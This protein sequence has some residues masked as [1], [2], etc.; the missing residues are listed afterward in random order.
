MDRHLDGVYFRVKRDDKWQSICLSDM[1]KDE[2][3]NLIGDRD[4]KYLLSC[5]DILCERLKLLGDTFDIVAGDNE[6]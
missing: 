2:R 4:S 1:T 3:H 6:D 5:V